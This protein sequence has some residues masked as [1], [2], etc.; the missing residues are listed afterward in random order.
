MKGGTDLTPKSQLI[1]RYVGLLAPII[2][3]AYG[4][5]IALDYIASRNFIDFGILVS[6]SALWLVVGL[7]QFIRPGRHRHSIALRLCLYHLLSSAY[8][9]FI[10]G[11]TTPFAAAW[12]ILL[13]VAG[14]Y[15]S[16]L[17][18]WLSLGAFTATI[19]LDVA[20]WGGEHTVLLHNAA[21]LIAILFSGIIALT[22]I[23]LQ[24][25]DRLEIAE[26][27]ER[28]G[29]KHEEMLSVVNSLTDSVLS[30]DEKG[31]VKMCNSAALDLLDTNKDLTG[32]HIDEVLPVID[33]A[34]EGVNI[35]EIL[36]ASKTIT[37]QEDL[38][39]MIGDEQM[40][41]EIVI[42][43]VHKAYKVSD[44][45]QDG[46]ILIMRDI[47]KAKSLEEE[48]DEFIS[49]VSHELR[50][51]ITIVEGTLSNLAYMMDKTDVDKK[52]L[53]EQV[54]TAHDQTLFL[55]KMMND[56]SAL[57]RAERGIGDE[58]ESVNVDELG[59]KLYDDYHNSAEEK[60][61]KLNLDLAPGLGNVEVSRL[62]FEE[63][64]QDF[65]TNAIKYTKEGSVTVKFT[66]HGGKLTF[67]V[68]DT[69]IGISKSEQAKIFE[70][71]YRSEDYRTRETGG[72][73]LGLYVATKLAKKLNT[74][75]KLES[76]LNHGSTF[77]FTLPAAKKN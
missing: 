12:V 47:T 61:L 57:S 26:S 13:V 60:G 34:G 74:K 62:Y 51:P 44:K 69:G 42:S 76:R 14:T 77:S 56:L 25:V 31:L 28:E 65:I 15:F 67:A 7:W 24:E 54:N 9:L 21:V 10:T 19:A 35:W 71:F 68:C 66:K 8:L 16:A 3:I 75:I 48:R 40:R 18:I 5:L 4:A 43:P 6:I 50:T 2:L 30:V 29:A 63:L 22:I 20:L 73:G 72:T 70:K 58:K 17:G 46:Y 38:R 55:S 32:H 1:I 49:V 33:E 36:R 45:T 11:I 37:T 52:T 39:Y 64:L 23:R 59:H 41:L 27:K 53:A